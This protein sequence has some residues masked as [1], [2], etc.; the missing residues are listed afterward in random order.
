MLVFVLELT[1]G[2]QAS[3]T[4]P[5]GVRG[6]KGMIVSIPSSPSHERERIEKAMPAITD[7]SS[8]S[9]AGGG[10]GVGSPRAVGG[11]EKPK[12]WVKERPRESGEESGEVLLTLVLQGGKE[13]GE[14]REEIGEKGLVSVVFE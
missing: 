5:S 3:T 12:I 9:S 2:G 14:V 8:A 13:K 1:S 6:M 4:H 10:Y 11:L 7:A